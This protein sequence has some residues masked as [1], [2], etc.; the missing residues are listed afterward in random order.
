MNIQAD[1]TTPIAKPHFWIENIFGSIKRDSLLGTLRDYPL[2]LWILRQFET[3]TLK[4][5]KSRHN[6]F[7]LQKM[8]KFVYQTYIANHAGA[9]LTALDG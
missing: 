9:L 3:N 2:V 7:T 1:S 4:E 8:Q 5:A 6:E